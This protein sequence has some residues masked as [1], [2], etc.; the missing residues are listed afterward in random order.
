MNST[1]GPADAVDL[2]DGVD[3]RWWVAGGWAID[4]WLGEQTRPHV[5]L[6][7]AI[8]RSEQ[9]RFWAVLRHWDLSLGPDTQLQPFDEPEVE[10]PLHAVWCRPDPESDW[11]FEL[12]LNDSADDRWLFR[13]D[14]AVSLP[15]ERIGARSIEGGIPYLA[16]E[17]VLLYKAKQ[18]RPHDE[19]DLEAAL[20]RL[21]AEQTSWL[22]R[23][24]A[25]VHPGHP[26]L[27]RLTSEAS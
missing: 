18:R 23:S 6:D 12:L 19:L 4:L 21:T 3:A 20:P 13:R 25:A 2:F 9:D 26:W 11:A 22:H 7:V 5:D 1:Y 27:E 15:L 16:P 24:I 17:I 8:L 10:P 14:H